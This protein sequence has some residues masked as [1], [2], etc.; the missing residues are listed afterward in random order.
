MQLV[1]VAFERIVLNSHCTPH[2]NK[3]RLQNVPGDCDVTVELPELRD[4]I[5][6]YH[7]P[8]DGGGWIN[9]TLGAATKLETFDSYKLWV[10]R[11]AFA[12]NALLSVD[13]HRSDCLDSLSLWAPKLRYLGLQACYQLNTILFLASHPT[14]AGLLPPNYMCDD[15]LEV[16]VSHACISSAAG[17]AISAHP[18]SMVEND[19]PE[20]GVGMESMFA[21]MFGGG[22][23]SR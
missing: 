19:A 12:S 9:E 14:L 6:H 10:E 1:D 5:V 3:V 18:R 15:A 21:G 20:G 22:G 2:V 11:L 7:T 4:L 13:L 16:N 8:D 17:A 23:T